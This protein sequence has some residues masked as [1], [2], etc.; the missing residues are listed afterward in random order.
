M[1]KEKTL[2]TALFADRE[3]VEM[4]YDPLSDRGYTK[5]DVHVV[6]SQDTMKRYYTSVGTEPEPGVR[7][8]DWTDLPEERVKKFHEGIRKGGIL[9]RV[10][11]PQRPGR[12]VLRE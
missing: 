7:T 5:D 2:I 10:R 6:M 8:S 3:S 12:G 11:P 4:G 9:M 1:G